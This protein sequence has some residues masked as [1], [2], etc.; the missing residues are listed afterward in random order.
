MGVVRYLNERW[1]GRCK[2]GVYTHITFSVS[3]KSKTKRQHQL[4][5]IALYWLKMVHENEYGV[6]IATHSTNLHC[7]SQ[8][9]HHKSHCKTHKPRY[10]KNKS[11]KKN[12]EKKRKKIQ[13][14]IAAHLWNM[15]V[16]KWDCWCQLGCTK[17]T[18]L[19][20]IFCIANETFNKTFYFV[21]NHL[22][23]SGF[24]PS[25]FIKRFSYK[26]WLVSIKVH[27]TRVKILL[28]ILWTDLK[29]PEEHPETWHIVHAYLI[30][31]SIKPKY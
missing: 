31:N 7:S 17:C 3:F 2:F 13:K 21:K 4:M 23:S 10:L 15:L 25:F 1:A 16:S 28:F 20:W 8:P 12:K 29:W 26:K 9:C 18:Y 6:F 30:Q 14:N 22:F 5:T 24:F 27:R 19:I 11:Q